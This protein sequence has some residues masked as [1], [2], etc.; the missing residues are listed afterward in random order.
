WIARARRAPRTGPARR[1]VDAYFLFSAERLPFMPGVG[2]LAW[3]DSVPCRLSLHLPQRRAEWLLEATFPRS[4]WR[5]RAGITP[6]FP[7]MP[8]V[9][10][11][12][13]NSY[14]TTIRRAASHRRNASVKTGCS[15]CFSQTPCNTFSSCSPG[16]PAA[17]YVPR[18]AIVCSWRPACKTHHAVNDGGSSMRNSTLCATLAALV[19]Y[20]ASASAQHPFSK[21]FEPA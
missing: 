14:S 16:V 5:N 9:G 7:V 21:P 3:R 8:V 6:D 10:T 12:G 11:R 13:S 4:Q 17:S 2:L 18:T 1:Q 20:A 19:L 15:G